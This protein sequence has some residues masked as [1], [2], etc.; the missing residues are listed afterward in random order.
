MSDWKTEC[1]A[2]IQEAYRASNRPSDDDL[3]GWKKRSGEWQAAWAGAHT[4]RCELQH[5]ASSLRAE[6]ERLKTLLGEWVRNYPDATK[7][8]KPWVILLESQSAL[9]SKGKT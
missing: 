6:V 3:Y 7:D 4:H 8:E 9:A 1:E 5:E 2:E